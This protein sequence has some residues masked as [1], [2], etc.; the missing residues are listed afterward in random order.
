MANMIK[1]IIFDCFGV[2][3]GTG[4]NDTYRQAGGDPISDKEFIHDTLNAANIGAISQAEM[5]KMMAEKIGT[6][7]ELWRKAVDEAEQPNKPIFEYIKELRKTYKTAIL[8][9]VSNGTLERK[10]PQELLDLFDVVVASA[11]VGMMK[12]DPEIYRYTAEQLS[13]SPQECVFTDDIQDYCDG[14]KAVG[15]TTILYTD[16]EEVK[17]R[18]ETILADSNE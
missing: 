3:V 4:F 11:E 5:S 17:Q 13:V 12:P 1:A 14:A 7:V 10:I 8:S 16:F 9:N 6:S 18:L 15:M 2:L